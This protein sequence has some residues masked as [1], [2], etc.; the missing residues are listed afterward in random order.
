MWEGVGDRTELQHIDPHSYGHQRCVF[1]VLQGCSTGD[2]GA[3]LSAECWL[4]LPHLSP[5]S[6]VSKL[7]DFLSSMSFIIVPSPT[8][9]LE[10]H[11]WSS[12]SGIICHAVH[13]SLSSGA[14][15]YDCTTGFY[16]VPFCQPSS[17]TSM[18]YALPP[19]LE[20][21]VWP[22]R[23]SIYNIM[24]WTAT[25]QEVSSSS[26]SGITFTFGQNP[27]KRYETPFTST[28]SLNYYSS[29]RMALITHEGW[30]TFKHWN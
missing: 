24:C 22:G 4:S 12:S 7:T 11:V 26:S 3:Q 15:V 5:T 18:E 25:S 13:R 29:T 16:L 19:S 17:P 1:L 23:R 28:Y 20:W 27:W 30:Y 6:L 10:W 14:S 21:Y 9:S 2:P 8:Q